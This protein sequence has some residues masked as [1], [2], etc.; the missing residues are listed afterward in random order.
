MYIRLL[1]EAAGPNTELAWL[2]WVALGF[3]ALMVL[4]GWLSARF[5]GKKKAT[6]PPTGHDAHGH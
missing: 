4:V 1:E 6:P 2:L 5:G 3:F